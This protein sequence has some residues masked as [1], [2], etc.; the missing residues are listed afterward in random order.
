VST[1]VELR[2]NVGASALPPDVKQRLI[3]LHINS[4]TP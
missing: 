1:A 2:C 4:A 3:A